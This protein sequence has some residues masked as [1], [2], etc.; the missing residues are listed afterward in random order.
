MKPVELRGIAAV[1]V[2]KLNFGPS[3]Y[4]L[5]LDGII[6]YVGQSV[7]PLARIEAHRKTYRWKKALH[8]DRAY[9]V[10]VPPKLLNDIEGAIIRTLKPMLNGRT[11]TGKVCA[12]LPKT[13][14]SDREIIEAAGFSH[15]MLWHLK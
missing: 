9:V 3:I 8:F 1:D 13:G 14:R 2:T 15:Y 7:Q 12:T 4:F 6:I 5:C 10:E 11:R